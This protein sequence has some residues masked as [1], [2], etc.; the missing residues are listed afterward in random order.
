MG[1]ERHYSASSLDATGKTVEEVEWD[2]R[3][4]LRFYFLDAKGQQVQIDPEDGSFDPMWVPMSSCRFLLNSRVRS[5]NAVV[6]NALNATARNAEQGGKCRVS[7]KIPYAL[8][9]STQSSTMTF[10]QFIKWATDN[11]IGRDTATSM[12]DKANKS[13]GVVG[14]YVTKSAPFSLVEV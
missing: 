1:W 10:Q 13:G 8:T 6:Q 14:G 3:R 4:D 9:D 7:L 12:W 11:G 2:R 5:T